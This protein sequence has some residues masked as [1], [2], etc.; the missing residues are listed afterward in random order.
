MHYNASSL[1]AVRA[2]LVTP[3]KHWLIDL[4]FANKS[5]RVLSGVVSL[6][7]SEHAITYYGLVSLVSP[8]FKTFNKI[9][10]GWTRSP[11]SA[12]ALYGE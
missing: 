3:R 2:N 10:Y 12:D 1:Q 9:E 4:T 11:R 8:L 6:T 7:L 5:E